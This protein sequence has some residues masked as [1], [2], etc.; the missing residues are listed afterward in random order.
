VADRITD[1]HAGLADLE[2]ELDLSDLAGQITRGVESGESPL[3]SAANALRGSQRKASADTE[4]QDEPDAD[5]EDQDEPAEQEEGA[6]DRE[7]DTMLEEEGAEQDESSEEEASEEQEE[8]E[9]DEQKDEKAGRDLFIPP[10][11]KGD[12]KRGNTAL[13]IENLPQEHYDLLKAHIN[14]SERLD[15]TEG[16]LM[17]ARQYQSAAEF[18]QH[19]PVATMLML[20]FYDSEAEKPKRVGE[21]FV[22]QWIQMHPVEARELASKNPVL[23]GAADPET[24]ADKAELARMKAKSSIESGVRNYQSQT[25]Q[26]QFAS[27]V[28]ASI[29]TVGQQL[30]LD[31]DEMADFASAAAQ[32]VSRAVEQRRKSGQ[33]GFPGNRDIILIIQPLA[34]R[35]LTGTNGRKAKAQDAGDLGLL[36]KERESRQAK[37]RKVSG[38]DSSPR[39]KGKPF[40]KVKGARNVAEAARRLREG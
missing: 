21:A 37:H 16:Q 24:L 5:T 4:D 36:F 20:D 3:R 12:P 32:R 29:R 31:Q 6:I 40:G 7:L 15:A 2:P 25:V 19:E 35:Y 39:A 17:E 11:A 14:R 13:T 28:A 10:V 27:D 22:K 38:R 33:N 8:E 26:R 18:M 30:R 1:P 9:A 23:S 34:Q